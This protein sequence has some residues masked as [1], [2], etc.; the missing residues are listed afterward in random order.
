LEGDIIFMAANCGA[1]GNKAD[2]RQKRKAEDSSQ[3]G[4]EFPRFPR[5]SWMRFMPFGVGR[6]FGFALR[7]P[8]FMPDSWGAVG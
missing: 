2:K 6:E 7:G 3:Y 1:T 4:H 5:L 8:K